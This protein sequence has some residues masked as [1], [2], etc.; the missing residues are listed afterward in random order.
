MS[1]EVHTLA[2]SDPPDSDI[3]QTSALVE[4]LDLQGVDGLRPPPRGRRQIALGLAVT[5]LAV[6]LLGAVFA[7]LLPLARYDVII[8]GMRPAAPPDFRWPEPL[9]TDSIGRSVTARLAFGARQ[10]LL[11]G[12]ASVIIALAI[13]T[14]VGMCAG[15]FRGKLDAAVG[16]VLD[17]ILS[18]P[19]L[20]LLLAIAS[21][22]RRDA[23]TLM[24]ALGIIGVP[25]FT[26]LARANTLPLANA[27]YVSAARVMGATTT[28]I[29]LREILPLVVLRVS[30][31][32]F[33]FM[34]TVIVAEASLSFLGLGVPPP[35]PSWGT[36]ISDARPFL[37]TKPHMVFVPAV[38]IFLT[39]VSFTILGDWAR[40]R[41][42]ARESALA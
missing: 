18:I 3:A 15:Y 36:M 16:V 38:C 10:S 39:V 2:A 40:R 28:R 13:G 35:T 17:A 25:T 1:V 32:A 42:D 23:V 34:A 31:Y 26:R 30:S 8:G 11:I 41:V 14:A 27:E 22:G 12:V 7:D 6:V 21:I 29:L 37:A 24:I 33:L 20:V 4:R 19:A 5:W 9:G